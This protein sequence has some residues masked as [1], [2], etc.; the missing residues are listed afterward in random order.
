MLKQLQQSALYSA[1][2]LRSFIRELKEI[3]AG[4]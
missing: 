1:S 3:G 2:R 4:F